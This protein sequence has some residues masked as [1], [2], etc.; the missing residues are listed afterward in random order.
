MRRAFRMDKIR[1]NQKFQLF[2]NF[3]E[4]SVIKV[5]NVRKKLAPLKGG[6]Y[7][8]NLGFIGTVKVDV[9]NYIFSSKRKRAP[10]KHSR[11]LVKNLLSRQVSVH[12]KESQNLTK[13]IRKRDRCKWKLQ[14]LHRSVHN[15]DCSSPEISIQYN[16]KG[17]PVTHRCSPLCD[18]GYLW[19]K[20]C[21]RLSLRE[22]ASQRNSGNFH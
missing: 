2:S 1:S 18:P 10:Y 6:S 13:F 9:A 7:N 3:G 12:L 14:N 20:V 22:V 16:R 8:P 21:Q 15:N 5:K 17:G 19:L 11:P 4:V